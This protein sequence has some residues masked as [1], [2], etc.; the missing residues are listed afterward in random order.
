VTIQLSS[1]LA[2][3]TEGREL[4]VIGVRSNHHHSLATG[5][6]MAERPQ[7]RLPMDRAATTAN[8]QLPELN[9]RPGR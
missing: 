6:G 3:Q 4:G 5:I 9:S 1:G 2:V 7:T 8:A